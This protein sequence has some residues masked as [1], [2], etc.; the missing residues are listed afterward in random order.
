VRAKKEEIY[1]LEKTRRFYQIDKEESMEWGGGR[2][3]TTAGRTV[4]RRGLPRHLLND[5]DL[6]YLK[7]G[8]ARIALFETRRESSY[9]DQDQE[10]LGL[11]LLGSNREDRENGGEEKYMKG[12]REKRSECLT[13]SRC[14]E[15]EERRR[16]S[17]SSKTIL[18]VRGAR[19]KQVCGAK[20][21]EGAR[22][23]RNF[24][25]APYESPA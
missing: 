6:V 25:Y 4:R 19:D 1:E 3:K 17:T 18:R 16:C 22:P 21:E 10:K 20:K 5:S 2:I 9:L 8:T 14:L 11:Y 15:T 24:L 7:E 12:K 23:A 13:R